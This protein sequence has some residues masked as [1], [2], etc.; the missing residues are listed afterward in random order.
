MDQ[1]RE[2]V[3]ALLK[4]LLNLFDIILAGVGQVELWLRGELSRM[5]VDPHTQSAILI[6]AAVVLLLAVLRVFGGLLR[7]LVALFLIF[8]AIHVLLPIVHVR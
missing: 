4:L 2:A 6:A 3:D 5:G 1:V 8:L 7:V